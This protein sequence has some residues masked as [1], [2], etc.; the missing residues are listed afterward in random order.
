MS[1]WT[2]T[3]RHEGNKPQV[4]AER[5][6]VFVLGQSEAL[7]HA[8]QRLVP[9]A[10]C[11]IETFSSQQEFLDLDVSSR[12][13]CLVLELPPATA[14]IDLQRLFSAVPHLPIVAITANG[15]AQLRE[16]AFAAG[17]VAVLYYP[18]DSEEGALENGVDP[19]WISDS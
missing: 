4:N 2:K 3:S 11:D 19:A 1:L 17:A 12:C 9:V 5:S 14:R 7:R 13:G 8:V 16:E 18:L 6:I 15:N 10:G